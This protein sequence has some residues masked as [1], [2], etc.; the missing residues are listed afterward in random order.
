MN[1]APFLSQI[2]SFGNFV[3]LKVNNMIKILFV[4]IVALSFVKVDNDFKYKSN[5]RESIDTLQVMLSKTKVAAEKGEIY[6]RISRSYLM[7][8][9]LS[10]EKLT[11]RD[12]FNKGIESAE[13][14][15]EVDPSN[16]HCY[17]WHCANIG[18]ECQ[19]HSLMEQAISVPIMM[20]DLQMIIDILDKVDYSP[21]WQALSELYY[22]HP[23]KS[24]DSAINF[25]RKAALDIPQGELQLSTYLYFAKI[26]LDRDYSQKKRASQASSNESK[27]LKSYDSM[28]DKYSYLDGANLVMPW[29]GKKVSEVSDHQ[30]AVDIL[31]YASS[32]YEA[33]SNPSPVDTRDYQEIN[34]MIKTI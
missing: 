13:K 33:T 10:K 15:F 2:F 24:D 7:L 23:F 27:F 17:M 30:E 5:Y 9:E 14:G 28:I 18:R 32:L 29:N 16:P 34:N 1:S 8:G 6:W 31:K 26:L 11:K 4:A 19:T 22:H 3:M 20:T 25:A 21:A 12:Y